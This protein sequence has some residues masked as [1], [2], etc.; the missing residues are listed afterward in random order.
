MKKL[1]ALL[2]VLAEV[3]ALLDK[4]GDGKIDILQKKQ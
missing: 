1:I 2:A 3:L 4:D